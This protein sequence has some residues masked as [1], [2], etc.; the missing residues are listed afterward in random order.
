MSVVKIDNLGTFT[1]NYK[2]N[3]NKKVNVISAVIFK[4]SQVSD[5]S[6]YVKNL[7]KVKNLNVIKNKEYVFRL[8]YDDSILE[9]QYV[10][11]IFPSLN[12]YY[13]MVHYDCPKF[14]NKDG[15]HNGTFGTLM[16]YLPFH[17]FPENDVNYCFVIDIDGE[18]EN[19]EK[20]LVIYTKLLNENNLNL[21][22]TFWYCH[23]PSHNINLSDFLLGQLFL[24]KV[25]LP[26][27]YLID[28]INDVVD[29]LFEIYIKLKDKITKKTEKKYH[30]KF[31]YGVDEIY[32]E[33]YL[34]INFDKNK[35]RYGRYVAVHYEPL[36]KFFKS[37]FLSIEDE[38]TKLELNK[39]VASIN[40]KFKTNY[41]DLEDFF[42]LFKNY[43][44]KRKT[45]MHEQYE[46]FHIQTIDL[47]KKK[48]DLE[49][50]K[51]YSCFER[52]PTFFDD[53]NNLEIFN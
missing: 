19:K 29:K 16:R 38:K 10:K 24:I 26:L 35:I 28:Y 40:K 34:K 17:S 11:K 4:S 37:M 44:W 2:I 53:T 42:N 46:F 41:S 1:Y 18:V 43:D 47:Y 31:F 27:Q 50:P 22:Y 20:R 30:H 36:V 39:I 6:R 48:T 52:I 45:N 15:T 51:K 8:Y 5:F 25:K 21:L 49:K 33:L 7:L 3:I 32:I 13:Q 14:K 9:D 23:H 12:K